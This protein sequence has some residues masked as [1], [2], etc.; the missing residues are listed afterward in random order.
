[1][2]NGNSGVSRLLPWICDFTVRRTPSLVLT[3]L[4]AVTPLA[5]LLAM[6]PH[7]Y[8]SPASAAGSSA[9]VAALAV[10]VAKGVHVSVDP[11]SFAVV[12]DRDSIGKLAKGQ[13][14]SVA[15]AGIGRFDYVLDTVNRNAD[16]LK[17]GGHVV[18]DVDQKIALGIDAEGV[19]GMI[20]TPTL[21]YALGYAG[22]N[23]ARIELAKS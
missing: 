10:P 6:T 2:A 8:S 1:M 13:V 22:V 21:T 9:R 23:G 5:T 20:D 15:V 11:R 3:T 16:I 4:V 7:A 19:S 12:I 18:G 14:V 17:L